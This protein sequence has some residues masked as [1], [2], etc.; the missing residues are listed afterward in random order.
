MSL[1]RINDLLAETGM[2]SAAL[3]ASGMT[4]ISLKG[5]SIGLEYMESD[6]RLIL[7]CSVGKL[8]SEVSPGMYEFLLE[9]DLFGAALGGGHLGLYAPTRTLIFSLGLDAETLSTPRFVNALERFTEKAA[10]L[11]NAVEEHL[12][13]DSSDAEVRP[14][15]ANMLWV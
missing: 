7:Y 5:L 2:P 13:A 14:F 6:D 12:A 3:D 15:T 4:E 11:I 8:S 9:T 10:R 1:S